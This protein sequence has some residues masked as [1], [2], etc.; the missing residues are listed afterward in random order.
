MRCPLD[1]SQSY[2]PRLALICQVC[3]RCM[4]Q[5]AS[6]FF[7]TSLAATFYLPSYTFV[8]L[9]ILPTADPN[10]RI[11][12]CLV[13]ETSNALRLDRLTRHVHVYATHNLHEAI[14]MLQVNIV[15]ALASI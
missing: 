12:S 1:Q 10:C 15:Y 2:W 9:Y 13:T 4:S 14:D 5:G 8:A 6:K 3:E 11:K 7:E